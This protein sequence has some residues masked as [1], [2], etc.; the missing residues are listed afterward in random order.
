ME[1]PFLLKEKYRVI[2]KID[3]GG[4]GVVYEALH[5]GFGCACAIK[6]IRLDLEG[7]PELD[8]RFRREGEI[9]ARL[10]HANIVGVM[11]CDF[12]PGFGHFLVM[13]FVKGED[14]SDTIRRKGGLEYNE[15]LRIGQAVAAALDHAHRSGVIHRDIKTKNILLE[16]GTGR[17]V[18]LDFG[19]AKL[20][21]GGA[22][23]T[24]SGNFLGTYRY[25]APEQIRV[26]DRIEIDARADIYALGI[27]LYEMHS[28][29]RFLGNIP[30]KEIAQLVAY[31]P[32]WEPPVLFRDG[33][34]TDFADLVANCIRRDRDRRISSAEEVRCRLEL[35]KVSLSDDV[36]KPQPRPLPPQGRQVPLVLQAAASLLLLAVTGSL[37]ILIGRQLMKQPPLPIYG[38]AAWSSPRPSI[39]ATLQDPLPTTTATPTSSPPQQRRPTATAVRRPVATP[40]LLSFYTRLTPSEGL[41]LLRPKTGGLQ[42]RA[43]ILTTNPSRIG[44]RLRFAVSC[45][46]TCYATVLSIGPTGTVEPLFPNS[47][48][49]SEVLRPGGWLTIPNGTYDLEVS[50]PPGIERLKIIA[51]SQP[52]RLAPEGKQLDQADIEKMRDLLRNITWGEYTIPLQVDE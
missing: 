29:Q 46:A 2:R 14:L 52:V 11:D 40:T 34:P 32:T 36:T 9:L 23:L 42:V 28:G 41:A 43:K 39:I 50:G 1:L 7:N 51:T 13:E 33:T 21:V 44:D 10:H 16:E 4:M 8:A 47:L 19:I 48:Q 31:H 38:E 35:C 24:T 49:P 12:E 30:E 15:V 45:D 5:L 18:V 37:L 20:L 27:V 3:S 22:E 25:S 17:P 26:E 6:A